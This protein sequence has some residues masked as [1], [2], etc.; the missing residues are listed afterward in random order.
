MITFLP[1]PQKSHYTFSLRDVTRVIQ[2]IVMVPAKKLTDPEK[3]IR[4]WAHETYRVFG[5][6]LID[7]IDRDCL[8]KMLNESCRTHL[9]IELCKA[10]E[11]RL[12]IGS[13]NV[14]DDVMR[15]LMFGNYM[16][17]DADP[18]IYDEVENSMKLS[19]IMNYYLK[20]YNSNS[21]SPMDLVLFQFAIEHISRFVQFL[22]LGSNY[23]YLMDNF[24]NVQ[25]EYLEF[26]KCLVVMYYSLDLVDRV[27]VVRS[28]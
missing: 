9:R 3:L 20:E 21:N 7:Q 12:P 10:M 22:K 17:P 8:M 16:E 28:N 4:L 24:L 23:I 15:D 11:K 13:T 25:T 26:Y 19:K 5:D 27:V 6:R 14:T 18:K 1:T 2:G